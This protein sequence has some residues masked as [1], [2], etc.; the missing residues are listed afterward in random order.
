MMGVAG[1]LTLRRKPGEALC[2]G[3]DT[4]IVIEALEHGDVR[5]R[6]SSP[7]AIRVEHPNTDDRRLPDDRK[8][9]PR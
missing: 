8:H 3:E 7:Q 6:V 4:I 9:Q 2:I 1:M 5:M